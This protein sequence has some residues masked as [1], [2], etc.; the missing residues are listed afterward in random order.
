MWQSGFVGRGCKAPVSFISQQ[1]P[2]RLVGGGGAIC[3]LLEAVRAPS[4][5]EGHRKRDPPHC[6]PGAAALG[7]A[8]AVRG[9]AGCFLGRW[10]SPEQTAVRSWSWLAT[11]SLFTLQDK[12]QFYNLGFWKHSTTTYQLTGLRQS[13]LQPASLSTSV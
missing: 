8:G 3:Q 9:E 11:P 2:G 12:R 10:G 5:R 4:L 1:H 6:F 13:A 7:V